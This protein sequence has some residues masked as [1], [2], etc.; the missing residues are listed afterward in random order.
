MIAVDNSAVFVK[1]INLN[2]DIYTF[3][4]CNLG[5][6]CRIGGNLAALD[7]QVVRFIG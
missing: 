3:G 1:T 6:H 5:T 2:V 4:D 7:N